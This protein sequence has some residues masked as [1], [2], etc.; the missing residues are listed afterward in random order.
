MQSQPHHYSHRQQLMIAMIVACGAAII[1]G[2]IGLL[3]GRQADVIFDVDAGIV[4]MI[5]GAALGSTLPLSPALNPGL[6]VI[7]AGLGVLLPALVVIGSARV[8]PEVLWGMTAV[9]MLC[10][11]LLSA[12]IYLA[13]R[14]RR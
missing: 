6:R 1:G 10:S 12:A 4:G 5:A 8:A 13:R 14:A 7:P 3:A 2:S 11:G 9:A